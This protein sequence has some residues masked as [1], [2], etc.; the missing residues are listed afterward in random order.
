MTKPDYIKIDGYKYY[1]A[2]EVY[3]FDTPFFNG[4]LR[5]SRLII[6]KK[7]LEENNYIY[8]YKKG[9]EMIISTSSYK[10][11][12]LFL[13]KKWTENNVP[14]FMENGSL[15]DYEIPPA[16]SEIFLNED[17]K[18]KDEN[19]KLLKIEMRGDRNYEGCFFKVKDVSEAFCMPSLYTTLLDNRCNYKLNTH[20]KYFNN[21]VFGSSKKNII[22]KNIKKE[23]YLTYKGIV[24]ILYSSHS[25]NAEFFQDWANKILFTHQFGSKQE[26]K[27]LASKL[28]GVSPQAVKNVF[29]TNTNKTSVIYLFMIGLV[30]DLRTKLNISK[31]FKDNE[32]VCK[33][34]YTKDFSIRTNQHE[35]KYSKEESFNLELITYSYIDPQFCSQ[36]E[37]KIKEYFNDNCLN[38]EYKKEKELVIIKNIKEVKKEYKD[39]QLEYAGIY[40]EIVNKIESLKKEHKAE[41]KLLLKDN[42]NK[43][44]IKENKILK[45][46]LQLNNQ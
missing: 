7:K 20:Y 18:F 29:N 46:K 34:G 43:L 21:N 9:D 16:P 14:K 8:A 6:E 28:I 15:D 32:L 45:L 41:I 24:K 38:I 12:K 1:D 44:L 11:A 10:K 42:E 37:V 19:G 30:K 27:E 36:A 26:K 31:Q 3:D 5:S 35:K 13:S 2:N 33:F 23:L 22:K 40:S 25:E 17:Q 39:I 4:C